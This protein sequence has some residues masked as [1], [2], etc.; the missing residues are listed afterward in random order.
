MEYKLHGK[1]VLLSGEGGFSMEYA[2]MDPDHLL[3]ILQDILY[4]KRFE[5]N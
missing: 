1:S 4:W 3:S 2:A 5:D